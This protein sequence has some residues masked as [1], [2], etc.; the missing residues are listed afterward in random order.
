M[1]QGGLHRLRVVLLG[2]VGVAAIGVVDWL[3][4]TE[5]RVFPL[6]FLPV[7]YTAWWLSRR[8]AVVMALGSS[9]TWMLSNWQ[10]GVGYSSVVVWGIN[11]GA[12]LTAFVTVG[13]LV[14][15]L[16][17][18]LLAEERLSRHDPLTQLPNRRAFLE[19]AEWLFALSRRQ[20]QPITLAYVDLDH[21]KKVNDEHGHQAGDRALTLVAGLLRQHL[22]EGDTVARLGGDEFAVLLPNTDADGARLAL[23]RIRR[24]VGERM[25][26][27]RWP[28]TTS[29]GAVTFL[30]P[31][32]ELAAAL[33]QADAGMYRA[34]QTGKDRVHVEVSATPPSP[35]PPSTP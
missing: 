12:Q 31:S 7:S 13:L 6:Y 25:N 28:I 9:L 32:V 23:E 8:Y 18:R 1:R 17:Q 11:V 26:E 3:T 14:A 19:R 15:V 22:R 24:M 33:E 10:A 5:I 35:T 27:E 2:A 34:K 21:F 20:R 29:I 16:R 4:G 30:E